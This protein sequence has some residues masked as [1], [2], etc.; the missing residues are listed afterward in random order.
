MKKYWLILLFPLA[1]GCEETFLKDS[2]QNDPHSNFEQMWQTLDRKYAFFP[3][4]KLDW[5]SVYQA[6]EPRI[7]PEMSKEELFAVLDSMLYLLEDGHV[8][9]ISEFNVSRNWQWYLD[10]PDNF[11]YQLVEREYLQ[12][13]YRIAGGLEYTILPDNIGYIYYG[14]FSSGF[15]IENLNQVLSFL[16]DTKGLIFDVRDN[17][18]GSLNNA[19]ALAQR[20]AT[21][22][23]AVIYRYYKTGPGHLE[24]DK[25]VTVSLSPSSQVNYQKPVA[26]LTNRRVYS[27][28]N[29][30]AGIM[31]TYE[32]VKLIGDTTGGGGGLPVDYELP[33][34]WT[35]R[36]SGTREFTAE[37]Q[38]LELGIPPD[39][40]LDLDTTNLIN[41]QDDIIERAIVELR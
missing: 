33:I 13:G 26:V 34:G 14:S 17:G 2:P 35:Y 4:K 21:E 11:N 6:F 3:L 23:E 36:F 38:E 41:G 29:T 19:F 32:H 39:I 15:T 12:R 24:F 18:G 7:Y 10:Y 22:S 9:L 31:S 27:A 25:S 16:K 5:D 37:G 28:A 20:F 1:L 40:Y 8:N 30:F